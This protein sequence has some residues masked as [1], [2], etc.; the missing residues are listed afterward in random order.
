MTLALEKNLVATL[1]VAATGKPENAAGAHRAGRCHTASFQKRGREIAQADERIAH[2]PSL[3]AARPSHRKRH[4]RTAVV[5]VRFRSWKRHAVV[6]GDYDERVV[7]LSQRSQPFENVAELAIEALNFE[8]VVRQ[9]T[10][11]LGCIGQERGDANRC[12]VDAGRRTRSFF[13]RAMRILT[14]EPEHEWTAGSAA[15]DECFEI[16]E[17]RARGI[18]RAATGLE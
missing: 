5:H 1:C 18:T 12:E 11:H 9:I 10:A 14:A 4:A 15:A 7:E 6:C 16:A 2:E 17:L 8:K 13:V 3:R